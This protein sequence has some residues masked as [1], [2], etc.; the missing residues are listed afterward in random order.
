MEALRFALYSFAPVAFY[1]PVLGTGLH[2]DKVDLQW[3]HSLGLE[4]W[5]RKVNARN[6]YGEESTVGSNVYA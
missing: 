6:A 4:S 3:M 1:F 2:K 5:R